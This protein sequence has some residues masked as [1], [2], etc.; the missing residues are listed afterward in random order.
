MGVFLP[1]T[2][3]I[4]KYRSVDRS[5]I[6][7]SETIGNGGD[8]QRVMSLASDNAFESMAKTNPE[9]FSDKKLEEIRNSENIVESF[10]ELVFTTLGDL[11]M[12]IGSDAQ[13]TGTL[14]QKD[15]NVLVYS[16]S[17]DIQSLI[18]QGLSEDEI[19]GIIT[20]T[21]LPEAMTPEG[22]RKM[23][24]LRLHN[25]RAYSMALQKAI[26]SNYAM[27]NIAEAEANA[28]VA[29]L[30]DPE[31][32]GAAKEYIKQFFDNPE[33]LDKFK[34]KRSAYDFRKIGGGAIF[35]SHDEDIHEAANPKKLLEDI[36]KYD[37]IVYSHGQDGRADNKTRKANREYMVS[38]AQDL[39]KRCKRLVSDPEGETN[40]MFA[41]AR[42]MLG[43]TK[44]QKLGQR[45]VVDNASKFG[46]S[47]EE[48]NKFLSI[49]SSSSKDEELSKL[50]PYKPLIDA[51]NAITAAGAKFS[52]DMLFY[53]NSIIND[54]VNTRK[55]VDA[56]AETIRDFYNKYKSITGQDPGL[57]SFDIPFI[58]SISSISNSILN[59]SDNKG[60]SFDDKYEASRMNDW[61]CQPVDTLQK[62]NI[63]SVVELII[64]L[65]HEGFKKIK[66]W[67][68]NPASVQLPDSIVK[69][70][71]IKVWLGDHS[72]LKEGSAEII[73]DGMDFHVIDELNAEL[74]LTLKLYN[75]A[76]LLEGPVDVLKSLAERAVELIKKI[77]EK[78]KDFF[79]FI[80]RKIKEFFVGKP[81]PAV[82]AA[83]KE[84]SKSI[85]VTFIELHGDKA[86]QVTKEVKTL[87]EAR[88]LIQNATEE[89]GK[90]LNKKSAKENAEIAKLK[91]KI[92]NL[93]AN[94]EKAKKDLENKN[95][96]VSLDDIRHLF[97]EG[98]DDND[99]PD[100]TKDDDAGG[101]N[102]NDDENQT[103]YTL[104]DDDGAGDNEDTAEAADD[105]NDTPDYT[106]DGG[107]DD[108]GGDTGDDM[109]GDPGADGGDPDAEGDDTGDD[110][111]DDTGGYDDDDAG[112]DDNPIADLQ[113]DIFS[114][115]SDAQMA[116]KDKEL[117]NR[118][119][120]MYDSID[121]II[122]RIN[123]IPKKSDNIAPIEFV[124]KKLQEMSDILSDYVG[125][126]YDTLSYIENEINYNKF[127]AILAGIGQTINNIAA[128]YNKK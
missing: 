74:D 33:T 120:N 110:A 49:A 19:A 86:V 128:Q 26:K 50:K 62:D 37:A 70:K 65:K 85:K 11:S 34:V 25:S 73:S 59:I 122:D 79:K 92:P 77:W 82:D 101:G 87:E 57:D 46:Y 14:N 29:A 15:N 67:N 10:N 47:D 113:K 121:N 107:G 118:F 30:S 114:S 126:T 58:G 117:R 97:L 106:Q 3:E 88:K 102:A 8:D 55:Y 41:Y 24:D 75:E 100:Y 95:E 20:G 12:K 72:V 78:I 51:A 35:L 127:F 18:D 111:G 123:D 112:G 80:A 76:V 69:D 9:K 48:A 36:F 23:I 45:F 99:T 109:G 53:A 103:D 89:L 40:V 39:R 7:G 93:I 83:K 66:I 119:F 124:S 63:D 32:S 60:I 4:E 52:K 27:L 44:V 54:S 116:I 84:L 61:R 31:K 68:C 81:A 104:P 1:L 21:Y 17:K 71:S 6:I 28:L 108:T 22:C 91:A 115:L 125:S 56:C 5:K 43:I 105:G 38:F 90:Y 2:E 96:A 98:G 13:K 94:N 16:I 64:Q 42:P